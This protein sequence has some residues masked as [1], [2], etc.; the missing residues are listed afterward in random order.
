VETVGTLPV[1]SID[2]VD[3][4]WFTPLW[5]RQFTAFTLE[6]ILF[7]L[8]HSTSL[9]TYVLQLTNIL[10][11]KRMAGRKNRIY[12]TSEISSSH[13]GEYDVQSC[14]L[15]SVQP[16]RQLWTSYA[17][18]GWNGPVYADILFQRSVLP[19]LMMESVHTYETS[20]FFNETTRH[21]FPESC[22]LCDLYK[23][24]S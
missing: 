11:V 23:L 19:S 14:L 1:R 10:S 8:L 4:R 6:R 16:R 18:S 7:G 9:L 15:G 12:A 13:G 17:T 3:K 22:H 20:A 21:C 24:S 5:K 2:V